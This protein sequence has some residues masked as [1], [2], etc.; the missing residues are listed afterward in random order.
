MR[1][2]SEVIEAAR[3]GEP[4]TEKELRLA[5]VSMRATLVFAHLDHARWAADEKLPPSVRLKAKHHWESVNTGWN[6]PLD[7]R[8]EPHNRP[9]HPEVKQRAKMANSIWDKAARKKSN[10]TTDH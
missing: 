9:C 2:T 10:E 4:C 5:I 8:V 7:K 6:I 3:L 1:T